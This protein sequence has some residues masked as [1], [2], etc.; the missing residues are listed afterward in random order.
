MQ[1]IRIVALAMLLSACGS[2]DPVS[3]TD[4]GGP[5][6]PSVPDGSGTPSL[7]ACADAGLPT[8]L[9]DTV[10]S[11]ADPLLEQ[12]PGILGGVCSA[13]IEGGDIHEA[14]LGR[15]VDPMIGTFP[16]GFVNPGPVRPHGMVGLG[17]D[18][19]GPLNYGGYLVNN[20]LITGFSHVHMSAGVPQGGQF[21]VM[22]VVGPV[23]PGDLS[24][25]GWPSPLPLYASPFDRLTEYS[26]PGYYAVTLLR[27]G[28]RAE[29][30]SSERAGLHRY[31]FPPLSDAQLVLHPGRDLKGAAPATLQLHEDGWITGRMSTR[32]PDHT[33]HFAATADRA[34]TLRTLDGQPV[35]TGDLVEAEGLG[36]VLSFEGAG[37]VLFKLGVSYVDAEGA[38]RNVETEIPHWDFERTVAESREAWQQALARILV[39]GGAAGDRTRFY[40]ALYRAQTFP[41]LLSDVDGRYRGGDDQIHTAARPRYTQ[42]SL[43]D[44]YRGQNQLLAEINP[45]AYVDMVDSLLDYYDK[46][47]ELP[48]WQLAYRN[49]GYMSG[50]PGVLFIAEALCRGMVDARAAQLYAAMNDTVE[51]RAES[52]ALG[53]LPVP[54]LDNPLAQLEDGARGAGTTLEFGLADFALALV[55]DRLDDR[56]RA[57][58]LAARSLNYRNL[59]DPDSG[60]IR[61]RH[62]DGEWLTPFL[63]E[64][65]YGFQEGTSWQYSWLAMHDLRG[66]FDGMGGDDTVEG[67][68]DTFFG[69]PVSLVPVLWPTV[70]NQITLF[71]I[72]Y[73]GNQF[74]PGNEH[75]LQAP[76]LYHYLGKPWKS[77]AMS[78]AAASIYTPTFNGLPGNDDLGA[79]SGWLVWNMLGVYPMNPGAPLYVIGSPQ[80]RRATVQRPGGDL[81]IEAP[82]RNL[83]GGYVT[84]ARIDGENLAQSWFHMPRQASELRLDMSALPAPG[85]ARQPEDRPPS[86]STHGLEAF[87]CGPP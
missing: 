60:W 9:C 65:P 49:P 51:R 29:L 53:Y 56:A 58:T 71:G 47:G 21:P 87:G 13:L 59:Q 19:E 33:L 77:A 16:P 57:E 72:F 67:R 5:S 61:P 28:V 10:A 86:L 83:L 42:F 54:R 23:T 44:S 45:E 76:W 64:S 20:L 39:E 46:G 8:A 18:T 79:L 22:P 68:L 41:N 50:D 15:F 73:L 27:Y 25:S 2:S 69:W 75:D 7:S 74:A 32:S 3:D 38:R 78:A 26:R 4:T 40:S 66:L 12:C 85:W 11:L 31:S 1:Y 6:S 70:Q 84:S 82:G 55:A 34:F 17:P 43:W 80:F 52:L 24:D 81:I 30:T 14:D 35:S 48:R 37:A 63:P 36:V 62:E